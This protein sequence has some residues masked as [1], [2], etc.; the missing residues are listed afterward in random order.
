MAPDPTPSG[1]SPAALLGRIRAR[2]GEPGSQRRTILRNSLWESSNFAIGSI[3]ALFLTPFI[4]ARLGD[5]LYGVWEMVV[6]LTGFLGFA[7]LGIRPAV[8]HFIAK[9]EARGDKEAVNRYVNTAFVA[10]TVAGAVVL[11]VATLLAFTLPRMWGLAEGFEAQ[12]TAAILI[13][14]GG[15]AVELPFNAF[16]AVLVGKQRY[17]I[18]RSI[19]LGMLGVRA[20]LIIAVLSQGWGLVALSLVVV[21]VTTVSMLLYVIAA[22]R[23]EPDLRFAPRMITKA[24][25]AKMLRFGGWAMAVIVA[26]QVTWAAD[27]LVIGTA[28]SAAAVTYFAIGFKLA[29][30]AREFLRVMARVLEPASGQMFGRGD[31]DGIRRLLT[32]SVRAM[33][34]VAGPIVAYLLVAGEPFIRRWMAEAY[35]NDSGRVLRIM[36]FAVIPAMAS[37][38][39][40]A[41]HYGTGRVRSLAWLM[42]LEALGNLAL[43]LILVRHWGIEGV[44]FGTLVPAVIVHGFLLPLGM[45]RH[46]EISY[47][48]FL[49][50]TTVGPLLATVAT[51]LVLR[52]VVDAEAAYGYP[53]LFALAGLSVVIYAAAALLLRLVSRPLVE[54]AA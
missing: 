10:F 47:L 53:A 1:R 33:L 12:A 40:M 19:S 45:C 43:S 14:G 4:V 41:I 52:M 15:F 6:S 46:Y 42:I 27:P 39:L 49:V 7:D 29:F 18:L 13:V 24:S 16:S 22:F 5:S 3:V 48:R 17:D 26:L 23:L 36:T 34:L 50:M 20:A 21:G 54:D 8:V 2:M 25:L 30:Y 44:A 35:A 37:A 11:A 9:H 28:I 32:R 51:W 38:P 31:T